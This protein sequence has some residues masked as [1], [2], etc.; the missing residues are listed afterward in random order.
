MQNFVDLLKVIMN[1]TDDYIWQW[2]YDY[3]FGKKEMYINNTLI[4]SPEDLF[5]ALK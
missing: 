1:D 3:D 2:C 4:K 5:D